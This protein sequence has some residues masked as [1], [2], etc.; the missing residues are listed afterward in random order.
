MYHVVT[1]DVPC[2]LIGVFIIVGE[3]FLSSLMY[4]AVAFYHGDD[5]SELVF[6]IL[7]VVIAELVIKN[8]IRMEVYE[9]LQLFMILRG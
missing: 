6:R 2:F 8:V 7:L 3:C 5:Y 9:Y 1:M 4:T